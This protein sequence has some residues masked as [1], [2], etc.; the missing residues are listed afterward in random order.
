[1]KRL[2]FSSLF[3][4]ILM[5][6]INFA[7]GILSARYLGAEGRGEL[8]VITR[9]T[10]LFY[11]VLALGLP[12]AVAFLGKQLQNKQ[13][14]YVTA[15]L[16]LG[17]SIGGFGILAGQILVPILLMDQSAEVIALTCF[18][19]IS[20]P[21]MMLADGLIGTL[22]TL[23]M[24]GRVMLLRFLSPFGTLLTILILVGL[25]RYS[26]I[27]FV[28]SN[29]IWGIFFFL[30]I[31]FITLN[32]VRPSLQGIVGRG[33]ELVRKGKQ[34]Y[35]SNLVS[36]IGEYFDQ[37]IISLFLTPTILGYYAVAASLGLLLPSI[38]A[39]AF[40][41]FLLPKLM[42]LKGQEKI[43]T[44]E[45]IHGSLFYGSWF[46]ALT[47]AAL[48]P[49]VLPMLY[50][51]EFAAAV[52]MGEIFLITTPFR[53]A[54]NILSNFVASEDKFKY[55][56]EAEIISLILGTVVT[57]SLLP[58][59]EGVGAAVGLAFAA[60]SKWVYFIIRAR[61]LGIRF[62]GLMKLDIGFILN[63]AKLNVRKQVNARESG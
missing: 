42:D 58:F 59:L 47:G 13:R 50:G 8:A 7:T 14:E 63:T 49:F 3:V 53:I 17:L 24:F 9:W 25:D 19:I 4:N 30:L 37:I 45:T 15:Y 54:C 5:M 23:N 16:V 12:A 2:F 28:Y 33:K 26:V 60:F 40:S 43:R 36:F 11:F 56:T 6:I 55:V 1:M 51:R 21:T 18:S 41:V 27:S 46:V 52:I 61:H 34:M 44:I 31:A 35:L 39:G 22:G 10:W 48:L 32:V 62:T 29:F 57:M 20:L 38:L